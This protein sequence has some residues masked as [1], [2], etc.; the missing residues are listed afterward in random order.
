MIDAGSVP[1]TI[2]GPLSTVESKLATK[3][4]VFH[5]Q[6]RKK[7]GRRE[8]K[9]ME[10]GRERE[11]GG[12]LLEN[13]FGFVQGYSSLIPGSTYGPLNPA[14]SGIPEPGV[15]PEYYWVCPHP[16]PLKKP[17][18]TFHGMLCKVTPSPSALCTLI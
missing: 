16:T 9:G 6:V 7:G 10:G 1:V 2:Y 12:G 4:F 14:R 3:H 8:G 13:S 18:L 15:S 17:D 11:I 5:K